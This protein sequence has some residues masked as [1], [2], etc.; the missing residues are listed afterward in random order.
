MLESESSARNYHSSA[1]DFSLATISRR[2]VWAAA[3]RSR[4]RRT[5][6]ARGKA[7]CVYGQNPRRLRGVA[8]EKSRFT[9]D[10]RGDSLWL[11]IMLPQSGSINHACARKRRDQS[12]RRIKSYARALRLRLMRIC[13]GAARLCYGVCNGRKLRRYHAR[14]VSV[15]RESVSRIIARDRDDF[16]Y[17]LMCARASTIRAYADNVGHVAATLWNLNRRWQRTVKPYISHLAPYIPQ[18]HV[19]AIKRSTVRQT[20]IYWLRSA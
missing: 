2:Y 5:F 8:K 13:P 7:S 15:K 18:K 17:A 4:E 19:D 6:L 3:V 20:H 12:K 11:R 16:A 9:A 10:P 14:V 1:I